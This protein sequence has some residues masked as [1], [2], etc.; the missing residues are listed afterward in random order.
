[1]VSVRVRVRVSVRVMVSVRVKLELGL[2]LELRLVLVNKTYKD[3]NAP[4]P[5][6]RMISMIDES[7][8]LFTREKFSLNI[9]TSTLHRSSEK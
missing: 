7:V 8:R 5:D 3:F 4:R 2:E 9:S 1:M 6:F